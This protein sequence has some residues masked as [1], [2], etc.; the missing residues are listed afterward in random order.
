[1]FSCRCALLSKHNL[2][3]LTAPPFIRTAILPVNVHGC[4]TLT[5]FLKETQDE[6]D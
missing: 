2:S 5:L 3:A 1:V 6:G 4:E